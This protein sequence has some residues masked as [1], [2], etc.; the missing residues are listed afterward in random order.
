VKKLTSRYS[1]K[2]QAAKELIERVIESKID[3]TELHKNWFA[4]CGV[5]KN[6]F[7]E[8]GREMFHRISQF[9]PAHDYNVTDDFFSR[10][11]KYRY[12]SDRLFEI[13]GKYGI[14]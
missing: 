11:R 9:Y 2:T 1:F 14:D 12:S 10:C 5:I 4:I 6:L 13:A 3:I 7:G 8:K